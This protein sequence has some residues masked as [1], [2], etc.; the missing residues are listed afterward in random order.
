MTAESND[1]LFRLK[2]Q[3]DLA[4][5]EI[6]RERKKN[7]E[8]LKEEQERLHKKHNLQYMGITTAISIVLLIFFMLGTLRVSKT[9]I[10]IFGFVYFI[11]LFEFIILLIDHSILHPITH[12]D[13][14]KLWLMKI[15]ILVVLVPI[16]QY[17][18]H[19]LM[20]FVQSGGFLHFKKKINELQARVSEYFRKAKANP[21]YAVQATGVNER[22]EEQQVANG[23]EVFFQPVDS[24]LTEN[25]TDPSFQKE[26]QEKNKIKSGDAND[27]LAFNLAEIAAINEKL[28]LINAKLSLLKEA[29]SKTTVANKEK[30]PPA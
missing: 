30:P 7:E 16:Q 22:N 11:C 14:L 15:S 2:S 20:H 24:A 5:G 25:S 26:I 29:E 10:R 27:L 19:G 1:S 12:G 6:D 8:E 23:L 9:V 28:E 17:I 13:P 18:E 21:A 4:W 3:K